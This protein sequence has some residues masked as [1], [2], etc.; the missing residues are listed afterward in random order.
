MIFFAVQIFAQP[1]RG[2][3]LTV[4]HNSPIPHLNNVI[5][6]GT[7]TGYPA[8]KIFASPLRFNITYEYEPYLAESWTFSDDKKSLT[9]GLREATCH[10]TTPIASQDV[11]FSLMTIEEKHPFKTMLVPVE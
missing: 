4:I 11:T 5:R 10:D 8:T 7:T 1:K 6:S 9:L 3:T 2:G